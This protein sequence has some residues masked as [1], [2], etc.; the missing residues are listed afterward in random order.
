ML[1]VNC[2][3]YLSDICAVLQNERNIM[4]MKK[5]LIILSAMILAAGAA[6]CSDK[7]SSSDGDS[8]ASVSQTNGESSAGSEAQNVTQSETDENGQPIAGE[9]DEET[10]VPVEELPE[11]NAEDEFSD[12]MMECKDIDE[13]E[14]TAG[15]DFSAPQSI[16]TFQEPV[17]AAAESGI[18]EVT[19]TDSASDN[20][21]I[22]KKG[23]TK[24]D[25]SG[26]HNSYVVKKNVKIADTEVTLSGDKSMIYLAVWQLGDCKYSL[27]IEYGMK[28]EDVTKQIEAIIKEE[29]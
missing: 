19:Y 7:D 12:P 29:K 18:I 6:G 17:Y 8:S 21:I 11:D 28:E 24:E 15:V 3:I 16:D 4:T 9:P 20:I 2:T 10:P 23:K 22:L 5:F 27:S 14:K 13:A 25:V 1:I 26:D